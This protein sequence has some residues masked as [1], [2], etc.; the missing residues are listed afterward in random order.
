[1]TSELAAGQPGYEDAETIQKLL[2]GLIGLIDTFSA[3][4][5]D[6]ALFA[7]D[8]LYLPAANRR[9]EALRSIIKGKPAQTFLRP[10]R[11]WIMA[12][13]S[14]IYYYQYFDGH[15]MIGLNVFEL[16]PVAQ[17]VEL[18]DHMPSRTRRTAEARL[19]AFT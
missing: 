18:V 19:A 1:M 4:Q 16:D 13:E 14:R 12:Q 5:R 6:A 7:F 10:D 9:Q 11:K 17:N 2:V 3:E 8:D 15:T